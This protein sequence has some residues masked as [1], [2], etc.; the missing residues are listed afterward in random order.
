MKRAIVTIAAG[1]RF[2]QEFKKWM[3][4]EWKVYAKKFGF[5]IIVIDRFLDTSERAIKRSP[6]WQKCILHR[7]PAICKYDQIAWVDADIRINPTAPSIFDFSPIDKISAI[8]AWATPTKEDHDLVLSRNYAKWDAEGVEY[9]KNPTAQEYHKTYG[10]DSKHDQVVNT[11]VMVYTPEM[12]KDIF[13]KTYNNYEEKG[14]PHWNYEMRP[15]SYEILQSGLAHW[16]TP[17]FN[18]LWLWL[19]ELHYP[20]LKTSGLHGKMLKHFPL[21]NTIGP[22]RDCVLA[23]FTNSYFLHFAGQSLDYRLIPLQST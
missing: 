3:F 8:D 10:L 17:R 4:P 2:E 9:I 12:S 18:M 5:D 22:R 16:L 20:F 6:A 13:E 1:K 15:V 21:L 14:G 11:G 23:A 19:I 7:D